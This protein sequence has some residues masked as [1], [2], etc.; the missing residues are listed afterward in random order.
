MDMRFNA[1]KV[2][3]DMLDMLSKPIF[4]AQKIDSVN[5]FISLDDIY[6]RL[7]NT[8]INKEFQ[9]CG[10]LATKQM[11][12]NIFNLIAHYREWAYRK[13]VNVKMIA[14]YTTSSRFE[15][16]IFIKDYR[17]Y[18]N[19]RN[20]LN[21]PDC[22]FINQCIREAASMLVTISQYI[23]SVYIIDTGKIEPS[24]FPFICDNDFTD[25]SVDW[26]FL[27]SK[28]YVDFQYVL[29]PKFSVIYPKGDESVLLNAGNIWEFIAKKE[30]IEES[31]CDKYPPILYRLALS[32]I[33][34]KRRSVPKLRGINWK[35]IFNK[36]DNLIEEDP[37]M[38]E[39][40]M[41]SRFLDDFDKA[42]YD[43]DSI[44]NNADALSMKYVS[45]STNEISKECIR[46]QFIDTPDYSNLV[47]LNRQPNMFERCP[48]NIKFLTDQINNK[49]ID[50]FKIKDK[51]NL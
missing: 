40:E 4:N 45:L 23:E 42:K 6:S 13:N 9:C 20:D 37:N 50:P 29:E 35:S 31:H 44:K 27:L 1:Y 18:F 49:P 51:L 16:S 12:S 28:D 21:N 15:S 32:I 7:K 33:G 47:D 48:I 30:R 24:A 26:N 14:Y 43:M 10:R 2:K 17:K 25:L 36:L 8:Q 3:F 38:N 41:V 34:D 11:I 22:F 46:A 5:I 39:G 19:Q